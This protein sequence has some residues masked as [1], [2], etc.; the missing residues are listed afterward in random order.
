VI[1]KDVAR[2]FNFEGNGV[3]ASAS[4]ACA[5]IQRTMLDQPGVVGT[6]APELGKKA[7]ATGNQKVHGEKGTT[8]SEARVAESFASDP[9]PP[10]PNRDLEPTAL[11]QDIVLMEKPIV[12]FGTSWRDSPSNTMYRESLYAAHKMHDM[13]DSEQRESMIDTLMERYEFHRR[14]SVGQDAWKRADDEW[15]RAKIAKSFE[16]LDGRRERQVLHSVA[17]CE[18][19]PQSRM[20]HGNKGESLTTL[21]QRVSE[22]FA[23][24][25]IQSNR[26]DSFT[27]EASKTAAI[28]LP[29][30]DSVLMTND[31]HLASSCPL[32]N[33]APSLSGAVDDSATELAMDCEN[34]RAL[35]AHVPAKQAPRFNN[36]SCCM[37]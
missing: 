3:S 34:G 33:D 11:P 13:A 29:S 25:R 5:K 6:K 22:D 26:V 23:Q 4:Q 14:A 36:D 31:Q 9:H 17:E 7:M 1:V 18:P 32:L 15:A 30:V 27:D 24:S 37:F 16:I 10:M 19:N 2:Q 8:Q 20:T 12:R 35:R 21:N 28:R